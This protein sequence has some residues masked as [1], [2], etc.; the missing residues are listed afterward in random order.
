MIHLLNGNALHIPLTDKSVHM[1]VTS[2]PYWGLR[3]YGL[4]TWE[5]GDAG[6]D[7]VTTKKGDTLYL[8]S[9]GTLGKNNTSWSGANRNN[10]PYDVCPKCGA[11][12]HDA[13]LGL[14]ST[15]DEYVA[16]MVAA[17]REVWRVLRDDGTVW[18]NLGD[19]YAQNEIRDR[20]G[21]YP[22]VV[23]RPTRATQNRT[24]IKGNH[25]LKPKDLCGI[26]WRV[27]FALQ[28]DGWYLRSDIIWSKLNPMPESCTDR[29][30]KAHEYLFLLSKRARY[31]YDADAVREDL[32]E[33]SIARDRYKRNGYGG[34]MLTGMM[35]RENDELVRCNPAGR[36]RRT[37]W[38]I[39]TQPYSGAHFATFP[40][41]LVEPC[42]KA[43]A[44]GAGCC[45]ECGA[46]F[47][48]VTEK[49]KPPEWAFNTARQSNDPNHKQSPLHRS[50]K[51]SG[52][53]MQKW[54]NENPTITTGFSPTCAHSHDAT[55]CLVLDPFAGSGT[56]GLVAR[57][58]GRHFVGVD[59][60][61]EYLQLARQR[62][63]LDRLD[64][65]AKRAM[66]KG[67]DEDYEDLPLFA[68][69]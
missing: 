32:Q 28:A 56:V 20:N 35:D 39:A 33:S 57:R 68:A 62:L 55:P 8:G 43:G 30:T 46:Q 3:D 29:P 13:G 60:S 42:I 41:A 59:L 5:G 45:P 22:G 27:A 49:Q 9:D 37:V 17:F 18:L 31:A 66:R 48:R 53:K 10:M 54:L 50:G 11:I 36:N 19:S 67:E 6:C 44:S 52:S 63:E 34:G 4:A 38:S 51:A 12:R 26:P 21:S 25:G 7:H 14:E 15:I 40:E 47:E 69:R 24:G 16:N 61:A 1:C 64:E 58:L 23:D 2:P 65:W